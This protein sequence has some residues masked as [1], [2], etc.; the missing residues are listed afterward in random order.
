MSVGGLNF[1]WTSH[2]VLTLVVLFAMSSDAGEKYV[3]VDFEI[4]GNVQGVCFRMYTEA[5][6]KMLGVNGWVKNTREGTVVGQVQGPPEKVK[7]IWRQCFSL[8]PW[9][10][11]EWAGLRGG[12]TFLT[13]SKAH[14]H[15]RCDKS[16]HRNRMCTSNA[17]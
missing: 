16:T 13:K 11:L 1:C 2:L 15:P 6:G 7:D 12:L 5:E 14:V 10:S 8:I 17:D 3:S 4:F 9:N